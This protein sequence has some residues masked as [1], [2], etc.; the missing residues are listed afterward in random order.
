MSA[1]SSIFPFPVER[2]VLPN[3]LRVLFV[4][5]PSDGL[6]SYW[7]LV[8]T[9][10]RDEVEPGVTG[11]AHF[12]EHMMF[13]GSE[14]FPGPLYDRIIKSI[15]ADANAYTT[16]DYT[17]YHLSL[18]KEDLPTVIDVEADRF[19]NLAYGEPAF[20]TEAGAVF[21]EYRKGRSDPFEVLIESL[22]DRA[23]DVHTY[24][25]TTMGFV[26]DIER[27]PE[28]Y[29]YSRSFFRRFYRPDNVVVLVTG[30]FDLEAT[31]AEI[32]AKYDRWAPGYQAPAVPIE[33]EQVAERRVDVA[34]DGQTLPILA[35]MWKGER[36]DA[37]SKDMVAG[38]LI[39][40]L[41][42]GET[43]RLYKRLVLEEQRVEQLGASFDSTRDPG[44][45]GVV[46][47]VKDIDDIA[48]IEEEIHGAVAGLIEDGVTAA[49]LDAARSH[50]KYRFL[51]GLASPSAVAEAV[52]CVVALTGDVAAIDTL[53]ATL[54]ALTADDVRAAAARWL[55]RA[56]STVARL[57][58]RGVEL[59]AAREEGAG[60]EGAPGLGEAT[61]TMPMPA[62]PNVS[63]Q[64]WI[65]AGSQDDPPGL[66]G[67]AQLTASMLAEGSTERL[68]YDQILEAL[69]P[70]AASYEAR[71][72]KEM[73]IFKGTAHRDHADGL[74]RLMLEALTQP[75]FDEADFERLRD[76]AVSY[77]ENVLRYASDEELGKAALYG[78]IFWG[79]RYAHVAD[80]TVSALRGLTLEH[81]E[82]F[83]RARYTRD[84]VVL[85]VGG[86]YDPALVERLEAGLARLPAGVAE[87]P[88]EVTPAPLEGR[89]VVIIEKPGE[90]TAISFGWPIELRRGTREFYAAWVACSW[91]GEH[92]SSASHLFQVIREARGM[93]YGDYAYIEAFPDGG[94]RTMPPQG[95]GRRR[96]IFEVWIRPV[97]EGQAVFA[98]RAALREV[99][100]LAAEGLDAR[101]FEETRSFLLKYV[102][103]FA[104]TTEER[105]GYMIDDRFYGI[106]GE[107]AGEGHLARFRKVL[108]ELT[109]AEVNAAAARHFRADDAVIALV[110]A[111]GEA[112]RD[113]LVSGA[114]TPITYG[115]GIEKSAEHLAEDEV[116]AAHPLGI[117]RERVVIVP[118][119][120]FG[121]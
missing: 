119:D 100:R 19:Q 12:F 101:Q 44:L 107:G 110:T 66:E 46:A 32:A 83:Y 79:T 21:G 28:Q 58:A 7:T 39:G 112:L 117:A 76:N 109:L 14:R 34:F 52:A 20:R 50:L 113:V 87:E 111:H 86:G 78:G 116:I 51:S 45:W 22:H 56:R 96:Q 61:L 94:E 3:G 27:M 63:I 120:A 60:D 36:F 97:P 15:G 6:V 17:A 114:P 72:D 75:R 115:P 53:Y 26:S 1:T 42:F 88:P 4:P 85:A 93:N 5:V 24:K 25:H 67:L 33:P 43:S 48:A 74:A 99:E 90:S 57:A 41:A 59:P 77:L 40:E 84:T 91:L 89:R 104:E 11:F 38:K 23:F 49:A 71:V 92:R 35:V 121:A 30:D 73:T 68:S 9:G 118:V 47:M 10:S 80:G 13:R 64:V 18:A 105:L 82:R 81:V 8:R 54:D 31:W 106:E 37:A 29:E 102:R 62:D 98:L 95:V 55:T 65:K 2:R 70:M 16:D 103:H 108:S 69:Y